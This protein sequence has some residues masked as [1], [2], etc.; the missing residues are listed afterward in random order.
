[1]SAQCQVC[2]APTDSGLCRVCQG[3]LKD[4]LIGLAVG[5]E[6]PNG[7]RGAGWIEYLEDA[8]HGKTRLGESA[9]RSS[10]KGSPMLHNERASDLLNNVHDMLIRWVEAVNVNTETL[11]Q[12]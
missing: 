5:Q 6:L 1:V 12:P 10:E 7:Q 9:R 4:M 3:E 2:T 8:A 11:G